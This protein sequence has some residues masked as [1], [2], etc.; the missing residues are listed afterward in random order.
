M[1]SLQQ[2][3]KFDAFMREFNTERPHEAL[4]MQRP[5]DVYRSSSRPYR[6]L[7]ELSYPST[8]E[9]SSSPPADASARTARKSISQPSSPAKPS[10]S[11]KPT[12]A[13]GSSPSCSTIWDT[14]T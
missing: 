4:A 7:P 6:G 3:A 2:Q 8:I 14:S 9:K 5:A 12:K 11:K 13:F 10:E 1:N